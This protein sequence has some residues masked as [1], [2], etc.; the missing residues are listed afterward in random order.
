[1]SFALNRQNA[2]FFLNS[3]MPIVLGFDILGI[4][5]NQ[6]AIAQIVPDTTLPNNSVVSPNGNELILEGGTQSGRNLF[7][8]FQDFSLP[9]GRQAFFNN[10]LEIENIFT[11][12]T[13]GEVSNIDGLIRG[14]GNANL[15]LLNP[16]GI[17]FGPNAELNIGGSFFATTAN[18]ILFEDNQSFSATNPDSTALLSINLPIGLQYGANSADIQVQQSDLE[19]ETQAT[20]ALLGGNVQLE[21]GSLSA[22]REGGRIELGGL[23][24]E[25]TIALNGREVSFPENSG[26][27]NISLNESTIELLGFDGTL[28]IFANNLD[29][30]ASTLEAGIAPGRGQQETIVAGEI[31]INA[32]GNI[33]LTQGSFIRN[34]LPPNSLGTGG[35][36]AIETTNLTVENASNITANTFSEGNAGNISVTA[37]DTVE[38]IRQDN[39]EQRT[40]LFSSVLENASGNG[41]NIALETQNL[42]IGDGAKISANTHGQG[43]GGSITIVATEQVQLN[44]T[45]DGESTGLFSSV[46]NPSGG[47]TIA[48]QPTGNGGSVMVRT[49]DLIMGNGAN[50]S[51]DTFGIGNGGNITIESDRTTMTGGARMSINTNNMGNAGEL[52]LQATESISLSSTNDMRMPTSIDTVVNGTGNG[53][54]I[55]IDTQSLIIRNGSLISGEI[56]RSGNGGEITIEASN[57]I[58]LSGVKTIGE[59]TPS[60]V[61]SAVRPR[62]TGNGGNV[63]M[64]TG[65]LIVEN[66]GAIDVGTE[67]S[68]DAGSLSIVA[69]ESVEILGNDGVASRL[70]AQVSQDETGTGG[71]IDIQ[72]GQLTV[73]GGSQISAATFG[74]GEG[75]S[76]RVVATEG[77]TLTGSL[78]SEF[79]SG[80]QFLSNNT[81]TEFPSGLFASSPG[82]GN[83]NAL[84]IQTGELIVQDGA[85]VSVSSLDQGAAGNLSI[86]ADLIRLEQGT[87]SAETV[88]G[89]QGNII[90]S[91]PEIQLRQDSRITT[92]A[93][94]T[95]TGGNINIDTETLAALE[96]SDITANA[97]DSF[98]GRVT[99][100][101]EG[102]FGTEFRNSPTGE[103]DI[104]AS[105][106][107]GPQFSGTVEIFTP[108]VDPEAGL[109]ELQTNLVDVTQLLGR[110]PCKQGEES[111]FTLS[112]RGGIPPNPASLFVPP[113][114]LV[115][116][117]DRAQIE[118]SSQS[119][120]AKFPVPEIPEPIIEA[121]GWA[122]NENGNLELVANFLGTS[123][124]VSE[125]GFLCRGVRNRV[126]M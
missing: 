95:A 40:G 109:I 4:Q 9:N 42:I 87:L 81:G 93:R 112:G 74:L 101:A 103:S 20:L 41:G 107:L 126:S 44:G 23:S 52:R 88:A 57:L 63:S 120:L 31:E 65:R 77:I 19:V 35:N 27:A 6:W 54:R 85:Q 16:A 45:I 33:T 90:L 105:S 104:T 22:R 70:I 78:S 114:V 55:T 76:L 121:T 30:T 92:N 97:E 47:E 51:S 102:I 124:W 118:T 46:I 25:G 98:G 43:N 7:H 10:A 60:A 125:T 17:I 83:A 68:G 80:P 96:N 89:N 48:I 21:Q 3:L 13:G 50:I 94:R 49:P 100:S 91:V 113:S 36:I 116:W 66:G 59:I 15:F 67:S 8:S 32:T 37:R 29:M 84:S 12:I 72:T 39:A 108:E 28:A 58:L 11:R 62:G 1:M 64:T 71:N 111:S 110:D 56:R 119:A 14:N 117:G 86:V 106:Q 53:G 24:G 2:K 34:Q 26:R 38:L 123:R 99:I 75:G 115:E 79:D 73:T 5:T 69:T 18:A 82:Q 122:I 61:F